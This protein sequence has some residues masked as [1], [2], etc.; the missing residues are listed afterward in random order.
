MTQNGKIDRVRL[1]ALAEG[2]ADCGPQDFRAA[3]ERK[4]REAL[5]LG[6]VGSDDDFFDLGGDF[7]AA[8]TIVEWV[9]AQFGIALE[10]TALFD[11]PT[12]GRLANAIDLASSADAG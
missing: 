11:H 2:A 7:L 4:W 5:G 12:L 1:I 9:N 3:L 10:P 6:S 8:V